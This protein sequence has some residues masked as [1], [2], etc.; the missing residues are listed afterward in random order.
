MENQHITR[1]KLMVIIIILATPCVQ[2]HIGRAFNGM[3][4]P[5]LIRGLFHLALRT[6]HP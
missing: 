1:K 6:L 3:E 5:F 4:I 2:A